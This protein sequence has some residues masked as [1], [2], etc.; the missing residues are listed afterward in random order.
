SKTY[1]ANQQVPDSAPTMTAIITGSKTNDG[2]LSIAPN[3]LGSDDFGPGSD[4][5]NHLESLLERAE[6]RGMWTGVVSTAR[7]THATPGACYAHTPNRDWESDADLSAGAAAARFPDIARQL[8]DFNLRETTMNGIRSKGLEVA[9][10]GGRENFL[11]ASD[12]DPED[13]NS[14]GK[15]KDGRNLA[16]E[17]EKTGGKYVWDLAGFHA[18]DPAKTGPVLGLFERSHML[19]EAQRKNEP[20]LTEMT[21]KAIR[22]LE[23]GPEGFFLMVEAGRIDHGHHGGFAYL[24]LTDTIE[25]SRAVERAALMTGEDTLIVVTADHSHTLTMSGYPTRG[26]DIMGL[27]VTNGPDGKPLAAPS[28]AKDGKPFTTLGYANGPGAVSGARPDPAQDPKWGQPDY[29]QQALVPLDSETHGGEDVA[30]FARGP[31]AHLFQGTMEQNAIYWVM[32]K[33]LGFW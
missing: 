22:I 32:A 23:R 26:N 31:Q 5:A 33:A 7:L 21:E 12:A 11:P 14:K 1:Q 15:R 4:P 29:R 9:M 2:M 28:P 19:Y 30:I 17:W 18:I 20:S 6:K 13:A 27:M 16:K 25:L 3:V 24:A 8:L 10:G